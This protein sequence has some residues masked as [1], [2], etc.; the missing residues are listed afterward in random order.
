MCTRGLYVFEHASALGNAPAH[1]LFDRISVE[2][3]GDGIAPR[4]FAQYRDRIHVNVSD[5]PEGVTLHPMVK[6]TS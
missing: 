6:A 3:L 1:E 4:T 5:M 2:P